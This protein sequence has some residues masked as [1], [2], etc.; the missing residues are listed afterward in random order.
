MTRFETNRDEVLYC[1]AL[2][3]WA[4]YETGDVDIWGYF[5]YGMTNT[6][7]DVATNNTEFSSLFESM[8]FPFPLIP[9]LSARLVGSFIITIDSQGFVSV[10]QVSH[11]TMKEYFQEEEGAH[12]V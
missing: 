1:M 8:E 7:Q 2:E 6:V 3:G 10:V 11:E 12:N 5:S 4:T 9:E